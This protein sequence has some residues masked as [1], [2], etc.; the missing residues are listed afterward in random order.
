MANRPSRSTRPTEARLSHG[1]NVGEHIEVLEQIETVMGIAKN[2]M[3]NE[4][5]EG[6]RFQRRE[7]TRRKTVSTPRHRLSPVRQNSETE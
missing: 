4:E 5:Y 1:D 3:K 7:T 6:R 2:D